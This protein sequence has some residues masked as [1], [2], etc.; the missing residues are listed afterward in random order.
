MADLK[1][2]LGR[3]PAPPGSG[4][5]AMIRERITPALRQRYDAL[6][7]KAW[8]V[9]QLDRADHDAVSDRAAA[10]LNRAA[11]ALEVRPATSDRLRG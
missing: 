8:L 3:P 1:R 9:A 2:K 10:S 4:Q 6:G 5:T 7:G 11:D